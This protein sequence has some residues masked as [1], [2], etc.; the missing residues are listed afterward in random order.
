MANLIELTEKTEKL[1]FSIIDETTIPN[2]VEFKT[3]CDNNQKDIYKVVKSN[4]IVEKLSEGILVTVIFNENI[5]LE[6]PQEMQI[7]CIKE[8]LHGIVVDDN[9]RLKIEKP[10]FVTYSGIL[11]TFGD[12]AVIQ[13]KET[14][15]SLYDAKKQKEEEEKEKLKAEKKKK[16][17]Y[18][19]V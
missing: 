6:L 8:A 7:M 11:T 10:D 19:A 17:N 4:D 18:T 14:I 1:I 16:R 2:W 15:K 13:M 12:N 3:F 9:D 5:L